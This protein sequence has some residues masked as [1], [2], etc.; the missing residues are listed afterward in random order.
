MLFLA[1]QER[2]QWN[3]LG[4][5][6][7]QSRISPRDW[8]GDIRSNLRPFFNYYAGTLLAAQGQEHLGKQWFIAGAQV[9]E[10]GLFSNAFAAAFLERQNNRFVMPE[11]AFADPRPFVHFAGVPVVKK[12]REHFI[13]QCGHSLPRFG[14]PVKIM[15]IGCGN[16]ALV[17]SL[18]HHLQDE[19]KIRDVAEV[20]LIDQ[21]PAMIELAKQ[22][23]AD[24]LPGTTVLTSNNRIENISGDINGTYDI[25]LS[26]LAYHHMPFEQKQ[27]HLGKLKHLIDHFIIFEL[28]ANN[29]LPE[30]YSPE[31]AMSVYQSYGRIIDFVFAHDAPVEVAQACVDCFLMTEAVSILTRPRGQRTDYHMLRTQWRHLF[32]TELGPEF[33]CLCDAAC[34]ADEYLELFTMHYGR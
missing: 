19:E 3:N 15:D 5:E 9:E 29:D 6:I 2:Q 7:L 13:K 1:E 12:S 10:D 34:Y 26:S 16:G 24:E 27:V 20:L 30:L 17:V 28:D 32:D 14:H 11:P 33:V 23:V 18:L 21:S 22:T 4:S 8:Q 25:G 31:L